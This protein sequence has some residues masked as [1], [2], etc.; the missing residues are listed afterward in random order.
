MDDPVSHAEKCR[1]NAEE[2]RVF[3]ESMTGQVSKQL[4]LRLADDYLRMA[5]SLDKLAGH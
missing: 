1:V 3:S 2:C 4:L 5:E